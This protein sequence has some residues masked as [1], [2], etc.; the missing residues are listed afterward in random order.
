MSCET[1]PTLRKNGSEIQKAN[2]DKTTFQL[3]NNTH[4]STSTRTYNQFPEK[5]L[6]WG[7]M[8]IEY[9]NLDLILKVVIEDDLEDQNT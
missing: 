8:S 4:P 1:N 7:P 5:Q 2:K 3:H 9:P 6:D